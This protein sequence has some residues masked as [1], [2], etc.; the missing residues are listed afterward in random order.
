MYFLAVVY[1][2]LMV[3]VILI[4]GIKFEPEVVNEWLLVCGWAT[5][6]LI[7]SFDPNTTGIDTY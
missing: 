5:V 6:S 3:F 2:V 7:Y 1:S 4:F